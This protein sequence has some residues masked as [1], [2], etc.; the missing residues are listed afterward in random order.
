MNNKKDLPILKTSDL[1]IAVALRVNGFNLSDITFDKD[2]KG[3]FHFE[4]S[5]STLEPR[6]VIDDYW[7]NRLL[8]DA[9]TFVAA[10][11]E[12][13]SRLYA[14]RGISKK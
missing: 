1:Y 14:K 4:T 7:N 8:V 6:D 12:I 13:K 10:I 3:V 11:D 2:K 9:R 5:S